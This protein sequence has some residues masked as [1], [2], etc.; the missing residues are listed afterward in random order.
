MNVLLLSTYELGR[1]PIHLA[2]PAAALT[3]AGHDVKAVDLSVEE[4]DR[5][6]VDWAEAVGISVPMHT[7]TRLAAGVVRQIKQL[8]S[9]LPVALYGLYAVVGEA[10]GADAFLAGEYEPALVEWVSGTSDKT[11]V[12]HIGRSEFAPPVRDVLPPLARYARLEHDGETRLAAAVEASHGCRKRCRHCPV[13]TLYDG[14]MRV[15]PR[16]VVLADIDQL[17]AAGASHISFADPDFLNAPRHSLAILEAAHAAHPK[18]TFDVTAKVEYILAHRDLWPRLA[19]LNLLFVISAFESV[20]GST[21]EILDKGHTT[22][23]MAEAVEEVRA[24]GIHIRPTW[25]PFLPWT[26]VGHIMA[27]FRFLDRHQLWEAT[28]P[29]QLSIRLLIPPGSLLERHPA[30]TPHLLHLDTENLTWS[31]RFSHPEVEVLQ[32]ELAAIAAAASDCGEATTATLAEMRRGVERLTGTR[33][34][35]LPAS[36]EAVPRLT[37][38]WFCCAEPTESQTDFI[39]IL[40]G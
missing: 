38:S 19:E 16:E 36:G 9:D 2:S 8:R 40:P 1:Q 14:R 17:V 20:D 26:E 37:E 24:A 3:A 33:L 28:D 23:E 34:G 5:S 13:P 31:W 21:L 32:K 29:V 7:A 18:V 6:L 27:L 30:V 39:Q 11:T 4:L 12:V 10:S 22:A 35:A 25:L 15:V